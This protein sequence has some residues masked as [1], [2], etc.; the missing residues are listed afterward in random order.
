MKSVSKKILIINGSLGGA[1]GN[2]NVLIN[3]AIENLKT[4]YLK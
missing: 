2:S 1:I 3:H 4:K